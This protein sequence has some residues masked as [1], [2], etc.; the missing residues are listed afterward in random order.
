MYALSV[1]FYSWSKQSTNIAQRK[2]DSGRSSCWIFQ[3]LFRLEFRHVYNF[4]SRLRHMYP[5]ELLRSTGMSFENITYSNR[6]H[7]VAQ[8]A[9]HSASIPK[10]VSSIPTVVRHI[11][12]LAQ[13]GYRLRLTPQT[14]FSNWFTLIQPSYTR[15]KIPLGV[16]HRSSLQHLMYQ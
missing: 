16:F 11:F 14:T 10:V 2:F 15:I 12:Q 7:S 4:H 5:L 9:R 6:P 1:Y 8:L 3:S 13:C